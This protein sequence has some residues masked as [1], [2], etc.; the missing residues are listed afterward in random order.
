[1]VAQLLQRHDSIHV[2]ERP[3]VIQYQAAPLAEL[4]A[5]THR[6]TGIARRPELTTAVAEF[7]QQFVKIDA[8]VCTVTISVII[9]R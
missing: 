1:M 7:M 2:S 5:E 4:C 9:C 3:I 8:I 6:K